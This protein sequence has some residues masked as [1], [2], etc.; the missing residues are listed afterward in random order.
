MSERED[1]TRPRF[2]VVLH[3]H[4]PYVLGHG[5]WPHGTDWL[6]EGAIETYLPVWRALARLH[7]SGR[8]PRVTLG[9]TPVLCEQLASPHFRE[10]LAQY[11]DLKREAAERDRTEFRAS[12]LTRSEHQAD[13]W[14]RMFER[15]LRDLDEL[16]WDL[17]AAFRRLEEAGAIEV[18][19]SAATHGYLPLLGRQSAVRAQLKAA[20][21]THERHFGRSPR[22][23]WLPECAYRPAGPWHP[24][25][26]TMPASYRPGVEDFLA[27]LGLRY[28]VVD[29]HLVSGGEPFSSFQAHAAFDDAGRAGHAALLGA[30]PRAT[31]QAATDAGT[32]SYRTHRVGPCVAFTRDPDTSRLV[33]SAHEGYPGDGRYLEFH[34][35]HYPGGLRY[36]R[37]TRPAS[38][39]GDKDEYEAMAARDV[40]EGHA[41]HF[42]QVLEARLGDLEL[43]GAG[44]VVV[45]PYDAELFGHWWFEGPTFLERTL[46]RLAE[47]KK[48]R[49]S[50]LGD[51]HA[52]DVPRDI[53]LAE[54]SWGQGGGHQ[55]W[56]NQDTRFAWRLIYDAEEKLE[57]L[58]RARATRA[59]RLEGRMLRQLGRTLLLLE[60]SDWPFL[61]TSRTANDYAER[62]IGEHYE[63]FKR[64]YAMAKHLSEGGAPTARDLDLLERVEKR[65]AVFPDL[66]PAWWQ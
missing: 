31:P 63:D 12:G 60:A 44:A 55:V 51:V 33:W 53:T 43:G 27:P 19:T 40:A 24:A 32:L 2:S 41:E 28:F 65:D 8:T 35:R 54:G 57:G 10:E 37:V 56:L 47:S 7:D 26:G 20:V 25:V 39:L 6:C 64:L 14:Q 3:A 23:V 15:A 36:W 30:A 4:M 29:T 21:A 59:G 22:G 13:S 5:R 52:A 18:I 50:T 61:I 1:T 45:A 17:V 9:M 58:V 46:L 11:I 16:D 66:D 48:V 62:R 42:V 49:L 38:E 34:K